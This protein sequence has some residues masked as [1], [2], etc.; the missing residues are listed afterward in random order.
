MDKIYNKCKEITNLICDCTSINNI[1]LFDGSSGI[2][3]LFFYSG[4][5]LKNNYYTEKGI[6]QLNTIFNSISENTYGQH[7]FCSGLS[8]FGWT[9]NHLI[10]NGFMEAEENQIADIDDIVAEAALK[11]INNLWYDYMHGAV[12]VGLYLVMRNTLSEKNYSSLSQLIE[13][14]YEI[15]VESDKGITWRD[16]LDIVFGEKK[17]DSIRFNLGMAHGITSI[18]IFL[19]KCYEKGIN[20]ELAKKMIE[21]AVEFIKNHKLPSHIKSTS[22]YPSWIEE[23]KEISPISRLAWCYG[24][25]GIASTLW[26]A[27][28]SLNN[29]EWKKESVETM[30]HASKRKDLKE[31]EVLDA[32]ICHGTAGIAHIFNRFYCETKMPI[33]KETAAYWIDQTL[34]MAW[35]ADGL[36]GYKSWHGKNSEWVNR[37]CLLEGIAGIG[38]VLLS[39]ISEEETTWDKSLLLS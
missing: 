9:F 7:T 16:Y 36:A 1:G 4:K 25:L 15:R 27:G 38:L 14:L 28:K 35:H 30:L 34:K 6:E 31:N 24:D 39:Y 8:G 11:D 19:C 26:Q 10:D 13:K 23:G 12:G 29:E 22:L 17:T 32:G 33:F 18:I 2:S 3:L 21:G 20:K 37:Y 5:Y